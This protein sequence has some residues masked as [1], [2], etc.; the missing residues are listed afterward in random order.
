MYDQEWE[1]TDGKDS[2]QHREMNEGQEQ[3]HSR[4]RP[5]EKEVPK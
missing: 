4:I 2:V 3:N 5:W 1:R